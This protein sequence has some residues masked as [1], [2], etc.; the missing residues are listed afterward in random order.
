MQVPFGNLDEIAI[1]RAIAESFVQ[2]FTDS[3]DLDVAI[4]GAGPAGLTAA[5]LIAREGYKTA[6]FERHLHVGGG[7]WGG[8]MLLPKI[9]IEPEARRL[10]DDIGIRAVTWQ[11]GYLVVDA[12]EAVSK[13]AAAAL[14]AGARIWV[15]MNIEDVVIRE[16]DRVAGVVVNWHAVSEARLHVDP[17]ALRAKVVI[18]ATGHDATVCRG[19]LRKIPGARMLSPQG[20]VPGEKPMWAAQGE[21]VLVENTREVYPGLV[22]A[23]MAANAV[24]AGPR[25]GAVFGGMLLSG[26]RAAE[27]AMRIAGPVPA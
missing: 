23:G 21:A 12:V 14:N 19:V 11:E 4:A 16:G 27:I 18:D 6:V 15:G 3:L 8:G 25:M 5:R 1:T 2:D 13:S 24:A 26:E 22:V 9:V 10:F 20:D 7:M 17:M